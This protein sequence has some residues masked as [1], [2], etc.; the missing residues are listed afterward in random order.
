MASMTYK[1][2]S[3][4]LA[5]SS[6]YDLTKVSYLTKTSDDD[7]IIADTNVFQIYMRYIRNY[8]STY[9]VTDEQRR[10]YRCKPYLLSAE[11]YGSPDLAWLIMKLNDQESPSKFRLK[12]TVNIIPVE[13]LQE[14]YDALVTKSNDKLTAN[15]SKYLL[16]NN[17]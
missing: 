1:T 10:K 11:I 9:T 4:L 5:R 12:Q 14:V 16:N 15:W 2:L 7:I 17:G 13:S 8:I 3:E 6:R